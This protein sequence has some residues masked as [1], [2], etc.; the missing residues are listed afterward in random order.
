MLSSEI[1]E[2]VLSNEVVRGFPEKNSLALKQWL[3]FP[4][5]PFFRRESQIILEDIYFPLYYIPWLCW[6]AKKNAYFPTN[7]SVLRFDGKKSG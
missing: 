6:R 3:I 7:Q 1:L 5:P 2:I 4:S